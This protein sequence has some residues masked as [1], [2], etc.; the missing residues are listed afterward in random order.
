MG[1][2]LKTDVLDVKGSFIVNVLL[3]DRVVYRAR[4]AHM[5]SGSELEKIVK[6]AEKKLKRMGLTGAE[7]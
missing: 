2:G 3:G 1:S 5:P 7:K 6:N 4:L